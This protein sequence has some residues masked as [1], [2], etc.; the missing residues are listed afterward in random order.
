M[1]LG[2][3]VP[4]VSRA[5]LLRPEMKRLVQRAGRRKRKRRVTSGLD[6]NGARMIIK[7]A[8][9]WGQTLMLCSR[10]SRIGLLPF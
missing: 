10:G 8:P 3:L 4:L 6:T 1:D 7:V 5:N 2:I 9:L